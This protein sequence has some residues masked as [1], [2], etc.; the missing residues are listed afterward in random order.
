MCR[1]DNYLAQ[2]LATSQQTRSTGQIQ[3]T[4]SLFLFGPGVKNDS[5]IYKK[6][7]KK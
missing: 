3:P 5:Y 1:K 7:F 6:L 2:L 4:A